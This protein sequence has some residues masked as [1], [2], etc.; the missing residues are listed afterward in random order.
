[1]YINFLDRWDSRR[2]SYI[3]FGNEIFPFKMFFRDFYVFWMW[4][5]RVSYD[6]ATEAHSHNVFFSKQ[7]VTM[8]ILPSDL[9]YS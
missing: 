3:V 5:V 9:M 2:L 6:C 7:T 4:A 8:Q 1:M